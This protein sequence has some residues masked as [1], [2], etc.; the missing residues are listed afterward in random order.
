MAVVNEK[1]IVKGMRN[2]R[3]VDA[4]DNAIDCEWKYQPTHN[5]DKEKAADLV[6][7]AHQ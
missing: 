2:L 5:H 6:I 4:S 1:L 3:V 7:Q